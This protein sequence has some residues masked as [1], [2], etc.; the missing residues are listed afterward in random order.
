MKRD[1]RFR[2]LIGFRLNR[3]TDDA[4]DVVDIEPGEVVELTLQEAYEFQAHGRGSIVSTKTALG[5]P[6]ET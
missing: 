1:T 3:S 5:K 6:R 2:A 4:R